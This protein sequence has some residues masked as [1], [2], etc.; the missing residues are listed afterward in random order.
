MQK[1]VTYPKMTIPPF[2]ERMRS[3]LFHLWLFV[4]FRASG[5]VYTAI[6]VATGQEVSLP[7]PL[8]LLVE[9]LSS[10]SS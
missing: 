4:T 5:T 6:D 8:H 7:H 1:A 9:K 2:Q 10:V 3:L